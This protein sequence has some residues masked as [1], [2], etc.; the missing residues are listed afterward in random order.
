MRVAR[1][2]KLTRTA[3][4][5][6]TI[7]S[8]THH[9]DAHVLVLREQETVCAFRDS[10]LDVRG[11]LDDL[12]EHKHSTDQKISWKA[13]GRGACCMPTHLI[14]ASLL[15]FQKILAAVAAAEDVLACMGT[16]HR[17]N[18]TAALAA[19]GSTALIT[20]NLPALPQGTQSCRQSLCWAHLA[21]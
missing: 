19:L 3:A 7:R 15:L 16:R 18:V 13:A 12:R 14:V 20:N 10:F 8:P 21:P 1:I 2:S 11:L 9:E 5:N 6:R 17:C 4:P